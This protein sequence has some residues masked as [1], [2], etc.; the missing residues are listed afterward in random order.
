MAV[1]ANIAAVRF[2]ER[3]KLLANTINAVA[4]GFVGFGALLPLLANQQGFSTLNVIWCIV[5]LALHI[6]AH[7]VFRFLMEE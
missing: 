1:T 2:N 3:I 4:L 7:L 5:A 6:T